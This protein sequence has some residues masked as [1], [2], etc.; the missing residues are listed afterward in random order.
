MGNDVLFDPYST[1]S[2]S[3]T[4]ESWTELSYES[5]GDVVRPYGRRD[6]VAITDVKPLPSGQLTLLSLDLEEQVWLDSLLAA[7]RVV[8]FRPG[9]PS[10]GLPSECHLYVGKVVQSRVVR[11][12][13]AV[14]RRWTLDVQMV[15][16]PVVGDVHS[17]SLASLSDVSSASPVSGNGLVWNGS[18]WAP[19]ALFTQA[20]A[21]G[22][23]LK[24][25]GGSLSGALTVPPPTLPGHAA[26]V[27]AVDTSVG[28]LNIGVAGE[29][30]DTNWLQ[31]G[32][33]LAN[34]WALQ[35]TTTRCLLRRSGNMIHLALRGITGAAATSDA[36]M[37]VPPG[38]RPSSL[39]GTLS[40]QAAHQD[41][42]IAMFWVN[43]AGIVSCSRRDFQGPQS[44][45][46]T[47][48]WPAPVGSWPTSLTLASLTEVTGDDPA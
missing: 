39:E 37:T 13:S 18:V 15:E 22:R 40:M 28:R 43:T 25:S 24:L 11:R 45:A 41:G 20:A 21:D 47:L 35:G 27:A 19:A 6:P 36:F 29:I 5:T 7:G 32:G 1:A 8:G 38:F 48:S 44:Y 16:G 23:F 30:G 14:E 34:G 46:L 4:V 33:L 17:H 12:A 26:Q 42:S 31:A 3:V 2:R 10:F 9:D